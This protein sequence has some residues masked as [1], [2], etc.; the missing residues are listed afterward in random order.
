MSH[1]EIAKVGLGDV[2]V[3]RLKRSIDTLVSVNQLPRTPAVSD[4]FTPAF[5]PPLSDRPTKLF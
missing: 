5:L 3:E 2:D 4:V 1:P